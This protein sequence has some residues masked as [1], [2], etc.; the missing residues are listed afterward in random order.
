MSVFAVLEPGTV[1]G[2]DFK[3]VRALRAGG[4]GAVYIVDQLST[5]KQRALKVM[6]PDLATDPATRE[7]FVLEARAASQ[8]DSDHVVEVVT[9]GVDEE[10]NAL[11]LVMELLRG[12]ELADALERVGHM[13][14]GDV[15]EILTQAGH[16]LELAHAK[17]I[18]HRDLKLE[19]VFLAASRSTR[20]PFTAKI[21]DFGIAKLVADA[22]KTGTQP[23]GTPLFMPPEQ[24]D[25]RGRIS[26]ASD[27]WP[28]GLITWKLITGKDFWREADGGLPML[29]REICVEPIPFATARAAELGVDP[30]LL[31]PGFDAWFARCV[32]R[33]IDARFPEA[34][35]AVR[36]FL[37]L[38][39]PD[40][41][42]SLVI[43]GPTGASGNVTG[44][45]SLGLTPSASKL[46]SR[47]I[48]D[49]SSSAAT[50]MMEGE[51]PHALPSPAP[52][53]TTAAPASITNREAPA[54]APSAKGGSKGLVAAALVGALVIGGAF[55]Y[56]RG[57]DAPP[58]GGPA[59]S[60]KTPPSAA[61]SASAAALPAS[62]PEGM[63]TITGGTMVMGSKEG[64]EDARVTHK[65]TVASFC[66][67]RTEVST[68]AYEACVQKGHCEKA[69]Q[70]V[71]YP[72]VTDE[73]KKRLSPLCNA[74][75]PGREK[76]PINCVDWRMAQAYCEDVGARLPTEA[77]W[78]FA[79]R[80]SGQRTYPWGDEPPTEKRLNGCGAECLAWA[81]ENGT[82]LAPMFPGDDGFAGTAPVGSY[83]DGASSGGILDLAG[84][85]WE[86]TGDWYGPYVD[87]P[88]ENPKGP[89]LG[90][91]RVVRGGAFNGSMADWAKPS[92]RWKS[93]PETY[94]HAIGF[95]CAK[96][97]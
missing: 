33:D 62:C 80:G 71:A 86:W 64:S 24:T 40:A 87:A 48:V 89:E 85:V 75:R 13:E 81:K 26:P 3:V 49:E 16:A 54:L 66:L 77:E 90:T 78:E 29:L 73:A 72:G 63:A 56:L 34:G 61:P 68:A 11:Y 19:N 45:G 67:D 96:G 22:Q 94:N 5:G 55:A 28:L 35:A 76:H 30:A 92:Y 6:A 36:S 79:A 10:T 27:V 12:E 59:L 52:N 7:R 2:R 95:R 4:M 42:R 37:E 32:N 44:L 88:A 65:V 38:V 18:V 1:F 39:P 23:L 21:L 17:G 14:L 91:E 97:L 60:A 41:P 9:A 51:P 82:T 8:V 53:T 69:P 50:M 20:A 46:P 15:A 47:G 57:G 25:R 43:Q 31:P 70:D 58:S 74:R 83:P 93:T 84:N